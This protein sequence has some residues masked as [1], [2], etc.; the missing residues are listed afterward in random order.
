MINVKHINGD[1][2]F[3]G[4]RV[5]NSNYIYLFLNNNYEFASDINT[6]QKKEKKIKKFNANNYCIKL[7]WR[8]YIL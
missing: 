1:N 5:L 4:F 6:K 7:Q 2:M 3:N 8:V